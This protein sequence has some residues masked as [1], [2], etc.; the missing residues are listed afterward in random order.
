MST[1]R[2]WSVYLISRVTRAKG[3]RHYLSDETL[4]AF[5]S[6]GG[7]MS[8]PNRDTVL[9]VESVLHPTQGRYFR[10]VSFNFEPDPNGGETVRVER[11]FDEIPTRGRANT[12]LKG[13]ARA[14]KIA[15]LAAETMQKHRAENAR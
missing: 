4:R 13:A 10:V 2:G 3:D 5:N 9:V 6:F 11:L 1:F 12:L 14:V 15:D 8:Q 7:T